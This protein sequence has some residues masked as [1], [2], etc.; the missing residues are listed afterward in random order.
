MGS[1]SHEGIKR[2]LPK[3]GGQATGSVLKEGM[4]FI[5]RIWRVEISV[6]DEEKTKS[7]LGGID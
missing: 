3:H 7:I 1:S 4:L 6:G 5:R 2:G